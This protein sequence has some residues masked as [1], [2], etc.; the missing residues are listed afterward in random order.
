MHLGLMAAGRRR[1]RLSYSRPPASARIAD[2]PV[3]AYV[4]TEFYRKSPFLDLDYT[5]SA[6]DIVISRRS[7]D[8]P[9]ERILPDV[10]PICS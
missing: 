4:Y 5:A 7:A 3:A 2:A 8:G 10:K 1:M 6:I 9:F